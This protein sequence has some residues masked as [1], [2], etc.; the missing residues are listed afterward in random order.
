ML[1]NLRRYST[2]FGV[3]FDWWRKMAVKGSEQGWVD[4][5]IAMDRSL[6]VFQEFVRP[7]MKHH[8][9]DLSLNNLSFLLSIGTGDVMV[10]DIVRRG[11]YGGSNASYALKL[12]ESQGYIERRQ[13][14]KD[15]RN[16]IV[17]Y[18]KKGAD[19]VRDI[20]QASKSHNR[21]HKDVCEHLS[22]FDNQ[23][24]RLPEGF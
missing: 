18:T 9:A 6:R 15:R 3:G 5:V 21:A 14:P 1:Q 8:G 7:I 17:N 12:L 16:G 19:I 24:A 2:L 13:D 23:C 20:R 10:N 11:H 4:A 22:V